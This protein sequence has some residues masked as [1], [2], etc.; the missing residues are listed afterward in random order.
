[1]TQIILDMGSCNSNPDVKTAK[2][3]ID[4]IANVDKKRVCILKYQ[5]WAEDNPQGK[6]KILT[7][8]IFEFAYQYATQKGFKVTASVFDEK[9]LDYL[10][11]RDI[12]WNPYPRKGFNVPFIKIANRRDLYWLIE[13]IPRTTR[14]YVSCDIPNERPR[15][16][17]DKDKVLYCVSQYPSPIRQYEQPGKAGKLE[18]VSRDISDHTEGLELFYKHTDYFPE[19][20]WRFGIS[21]LEKHYRLPDSTGPDAGAFAITPR[22]LKEIL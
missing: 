1:M 5:L 7:H 18:L 9:S 12:V 16:L 8:E 3:I 17:G 10:L 11:N 15:G 14:V 4:S 21:T 6:N 2:K 22:E 19:I 13:K 20:R